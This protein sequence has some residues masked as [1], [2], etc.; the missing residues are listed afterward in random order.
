MSN[1]IVVSLPLVPAMVP[2]SA[3]LFTYTNWCG[4]TEK[5]RV[6]PINLQY[7]TTPEHPEPTW[8]LFSYCTDRKANRSFMLSKMS[9][10][11]AP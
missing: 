7:G 2:G 6:I 4:V 11:R 9:D 8:L 1:K 5:R 10:V 3:L